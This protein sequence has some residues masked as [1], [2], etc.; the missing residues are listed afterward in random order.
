M[1]S[2]SSTSVSLVLAGVILKISIYGVLRFVVSSYVIVMRYISVVVGAVVS[3]GVVL[4]VVS[5][6]RYV[7]I[8][9]I[10]AFR[11]FCI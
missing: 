2:E 8:K 4:V 10:I 5:I 1:H 11:R 6:C 7:D 3:V 9:K